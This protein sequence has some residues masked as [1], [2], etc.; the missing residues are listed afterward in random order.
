MKKNVIRLFVFISIIILLRIFLVEVYVVRKDS[1][2]NTYRD[3]DRVLILKNLF[4]VKR[5]N[6]LVFRRDNEILIKRCVGLPGD[7]LKIINGNIYINGNQLDV[8]T[9]AII[10]E[11]GNPEDF[12][13]K[14]SIYFSYG[15][16]WNLSDFGPY[17]IPFKGM[18]I[19]LTHEMYSMYS[20][21]IAKESLDFRIDSSTGKAYQ[22]YYTINHDY[23]FLI[24]DN[25]L[26]SEDS[27]AFGPIIDADIQ[28]N[29]FFK[30]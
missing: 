9:N 24:G 22:K 2:Q 28:G 18:R 5:N 17:V 3:G 20:Q 13:A 14:S 15:R 30:F 21:I 8:P 26:H 12:I 16:N 25:R 19:Q 1:M 10:S 27:R 23:F 29:V 6:I 4:T 11:T 7:T